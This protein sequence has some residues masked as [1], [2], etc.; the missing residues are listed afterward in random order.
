MALELSPPVLADL[1][2]AMSGEV[3]PSPRRR[4]E[5]STD[6]SN[7]RLPPQAVAFPRTRADVTAIIDAARSHSLPITSRGGGTSI[8]GNSVG[9]GLVIDFS[10]HLNSILELDPTNR[11]ARVEPGVIMSDLQ[12]AAAP[13]GLRFGPDPSTQNRATFGGMIGN[14]ACGPRAV[15]YGRTADNTVSLEVIDGRGG[16]FTAG[17][18]LDAV[19]GLAEII[20]GSL[21]VIRPEFGRFSRQVSG[22]SLEHLLPEHGRDLA[23]FLVG[24]EGTLVTLTEATLALVDVPSSP[25]LVV[26]GYPSMPEAADAV[27]A[28]LAHNPVAIEGFDADLVGAVRR[29]QGAGSVPELPPGGGW[30]FVEVA[31]DTQ[32]EAHSRAKKLAADAG[33]SAVR[34]LPAGPE[35]SALWRIR[36]DG[37]GL[38]GR[39]A[40]GAQA[41]PG[42][43]DAA[44]PPGALGAYLRE[45]EDLLGT[46]NLSGM[47]YGHFGDG[48]LHLRLDF[49]LEPAAA[50]ASP[51]SSGTGTR[52]FRDFMFDA[53]RLVAKY[54]GSASGEHGDGRAR[55]ELLPLQYSP[56]AIEIFAGIKHLFDP[57]NLLNPGVLVDPDPLDSHLRRP[58]ALPIRPLGG[59][60][61]AHDGGDFTHAVHRCVGVGKCRA[62]NTPEGGFMCPSYLATKDEK[63][64]TRGRARVL[65]EVTSGDLHWSDPA[66]TESLDLCLSCKA[67]ALDCPAGVD[68]AQYKSEVLHRQ[69]KGKLRP[70][71][72][73]SL[74]WLPRWGKAITAVPG[75]PRLINA[76]VG[77]RPVGK[78]VLAG[79]G[80]DTRRNMVAFNRAPFHRWARTRARVARAEDLRPA[81][82]DSTASPGRAGLGTVVL[83]ADPFSNYLDDAGA[84]ATLELLTRAGYDVALPPTPVTAALTWITTGQLTAAKRELRKTLRVLAPYAAAGIPIVGVEPSEIAALRSDL[85]D[86]LGGDP[87]AGQ[88]SAGVVTLAELLTGGAGPPAADLDLPDLTGRTIVVQPHCHQYSVIGYAADRALI[89]RTGAAVVELAGC[90][91]MAGNFG[92]EKGHYDVSVAV[93]NSALLPSLSEAPE[94]SIYLADGYSC[95]TQA[96]DLAGV[97]G[98]TLP[99]LLA[100]AG[101]TRSQGG[102]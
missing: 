32:A 15:A 31:G 58:R 45:L 19:P 46:Y 41:W 37:A 90:C 81:S 79:G 87:R 50:G 44:V 18:G 86:L 53:T 89:K 13:H 5:Y 77:L 48:C 49:P 38:A 71:S 57:G 2:D 82:P 102:R 62:N 96:K 12:A 92:M 43:E 84:R 34:I 66:V 11:I 10:R 68:I 95:R 40:S 67:C 47:P 17:R 35:A 3:D 100:G 7:Y 42:W 75:M 20:Q 16:E 39:T 36:A 54:G 76:V 65:Q 64:S 23:K 22:Y 83:W 101:L 73:Y 98:M 55:S 9:P 99:E 28:L 97:R 78:L 85:V 91:G 8:A 26:L 59:F 21:G 51:D 14:N 69:H 80:M 29:H 63:D 56:E 1:R 27:P 88:L 60:G 70:I 94:G 61:F 4:A 93:A 24:S 25:T 72:H 30:L 6:A 52:A 33:T 74:G